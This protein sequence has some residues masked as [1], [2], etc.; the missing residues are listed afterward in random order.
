VRHYRP[1]SKTPF[2]PA[3]WGWVPAFAGTNGRKDHMRELGRGADFR[4]KNKPIG[5]HGS[6]AGAG[7]ASASVSP[8]M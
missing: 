4:R 6:R 1:G 8:M 3:L 5:V 7:R 2:I